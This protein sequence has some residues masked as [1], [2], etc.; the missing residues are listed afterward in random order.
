M[1]NLT[2]SVIQRITSTGSMHIN[3]G[4]CCLH[5][6]IVA[7]V[8]GPSGA[9]KHGS[10]KR[11]HIVTCAAYGNRAGIRGHCLPPPM[12]EPEQMIHSKKGNIR[13][14]SSHELLLVYFRGAARNILSAPFGSTCHQ[15]VTRGIGLVQVVHMLSRCWRKSRRR[16]GTCRYRLGPKHEVWACPPLSHYHKNAMNLVSPV[17]P[18]GQKTASTAQV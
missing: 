13:M 3:V 10:R 15:L 6:N 2:I 16:F 1:I 5:N 17:E 9:D 11:T 4:M 8:T 18:T 14:I 7:V 12:V